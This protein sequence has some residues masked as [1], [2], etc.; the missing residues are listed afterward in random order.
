MFY[1]LIAVIVLYDVDKVS[2]SNQRL[3]KWMIDS[4]SDT[5][6]I[7][8]TCQDES[9][10]LDSMKS[11]CKLICIGVPN[12]REVR[13]LAHSIVLHSIIWIT[14]PTNIEKIIRLWIF[15]L[16]YQRK[17]VLIFLQV[18]LLP[19]QVNLGKT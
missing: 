3:I 6:K 14:S 17:K 4:S 7:L 10:I 11:R 18:L 15:L 12:T 2:E 8:M 5:H 16:T 19:S 9:H 13:F 1:L